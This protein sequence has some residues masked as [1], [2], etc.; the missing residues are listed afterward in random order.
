M[1]QQ[2]G[3]GVAGVDAALDPNDGG[4]VRTPVG[5]GQRVGK[6][7]DG[8]GAAFVAVAALVVAVGGPERRR[9]GR[10][11][12]DPLVQGRLVVLDADDQGDVGGCRDGEKFFWQCSASS[13]TTAPGAR[14]SS[15]SSACAAG[16]SGIMY[17]LFTPGSENP[18]AR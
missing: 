18:W 9:G 14:P 13:V 8:N 15:A 5:V 7:E 3:L 11:L 1:A 6:I 4:D 10:D 12:L 2:P 17:T 16:N